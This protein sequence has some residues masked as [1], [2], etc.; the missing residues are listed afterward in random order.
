MKLAILLALLALSTFAQKVTIESDDTVDFSQYKTFSIV[1]GEL[2]AKSAALNN[3][4]IHRKIEE[5]IRKRLTEKGL[6][7]VSTRP[8]LNVRF[9][10]GAP[11]RNERDVVA[12][13]PY[14]GVRRVRVVYTDGT[15]VI[16]LRDTSRKELVWRSQAVDSESDASKI[17]GHLDD[18]V[19]KSFEKYPPKKK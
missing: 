18:M 4:L 13:G 1:N 19:K 5:N 2:N 7:E 14:G 8:D 11:R 12:V 6:T 9:N 10:L 3:D 16:D 15:L 17:A